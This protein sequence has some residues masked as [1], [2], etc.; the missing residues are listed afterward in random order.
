MLAP[1]VAGMPAFRARQAD[2]LECGAAGW[3]AGAM[4]TATRVEHMRAR[5]KELAPRAPGVEHALAAIGRDRRYG[6]GLLAGALA[7]RLFGA[8]LPFALMLAV[9]LG[10]AASADRDAAEEAADATGISEAVLLSV[11]D[12]AKLSSGTRWVVV[13]GSFVALLWAAIWAAR[14]IRAV[15]QIAWTGSVER[16]GRPLHGALILIAAIVAVVAVISGAAAAREHLGTIG[17]VLAF[18]VT[19]AF[20]GIWLGLEWL[21]PHADAPL[22][23]LIPGAILV[24]VGI[25]VVHLGTVLFIGAKV[26]RASATY[27]TLGVAFTVLAWLYLLS[28]IVVASAML[29]AARWEH[30]AQR[31]PRPRGTSARP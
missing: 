4:R 18:A 21:L 25:Q 14:A 23:A 24:A 31:H 27:G 13:A 6:G 28:R 15:H 19:L 7:F 20:F 30:R 2:A 22:R 3:Q 1:V 12:S 26:A 8:L 29:N 5:A 11:A 9:L 17:L 16:M 10:Y